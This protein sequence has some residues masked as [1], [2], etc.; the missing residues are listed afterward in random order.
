[1]TSRI[2]YNEYALKYD[3]QTG[4]FTVG[5]IVY[6]ATSGA[7][8]TI[9]RIDRSGIT[10]ILYLESIT[11]TFQ[12]NEV[13][14]EASYEGELITNGIFDADT[15]W[16][17][18]VGI[19]I[20]GGVAVFTSV[21][22][23]ETLYQ[24]GI[25]EDAKF[26]YW[27]LDISGYS[28]GQVT[29]HAGGGGITAADGSYS[30]VYQNITVTYFG[31]YA[32]TVAATTL[33]IDNV[34][35]KKVTNAALANGTVQSPV[36]I[37]LAITRQGV[38]PNYKQEKYSDMSSSGKMQVI[39][40]HGIQEM[41]FEGMF[42]RANYYNLIAWWSWA[43]QGKVWGFA[44]D[45]SKMVSTTLDGGAASGQKTIPLTTT[46]GLTAGDFCFIKQE[47]QDNAFEVVEIAS[48]AAGV[49][50]TT[51]ANLKFDYTSDDTFRHMDYWPDVIS[52]DSS[53]KPT[54]TGVNAVTG[55]YYRNT[56]NFIEA[57]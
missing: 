36:T 40:F 27:E 37:D 34:V 21:A 16:N 8:A 51:V 30:G 33:N 55:K 1:M 57:L 31:I 14:Y 35:V 24:S 20:A 28:S 41:T 52:T 12:D 7:Y 42:T 18:G 13:V 19:T 44:V 45:S 32:A 15:N 10:G 39:N 49:S 5:N 25:L 50:I 56:F 48:V 4:A 3:A 22:Q 23:N 2:V 9:K 54:R 26:Y 11:G 43:R 53:F 47:T 29:I 38:V 6:G 46:T 17:K